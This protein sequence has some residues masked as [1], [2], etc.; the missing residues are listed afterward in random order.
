[1][2]KNHAKILVL[3]VDFVY[4]FAL[5][6]YVYKSKKDSKDQESMQ[7]STTPVPRFQMGK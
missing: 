5:G 4:Y 1:M 2:Q 3:R 7:S 6:T